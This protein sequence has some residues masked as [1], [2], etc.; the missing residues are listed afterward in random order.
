[1]PIVLR[2]SS[3]IGFPQPDQ[4]MFFFIRLD[5]CDQQMM[6]WQSFRCFRF[7]I[8]LLDGVSSKAIS[9]KEWMDDAGGEQGVTTAAHVL[10]HVVVVGTSNN[11]LVSSVEVILL[12]ALNTLSLSLLATAGLQKSK[13][14]VESPSTS[15]SILPAC[16]D[17]H[18]S[19][20]TSKESLAA[21]AAGLF[22]C[23]L[24]LHMTTVL[25]W[26]MVLRWI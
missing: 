12:P 13:F 10:V 8:L 9:P 23:V 1:M 26:M 22:S 11:I 2:C 24:R 15:T 21:L 7:V 6:T 4:T 14:Q 16:Q 3:Q 20:Q 5:S 17:L 18:V 25:R 19:C